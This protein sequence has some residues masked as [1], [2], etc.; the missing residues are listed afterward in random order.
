MISSKAEQVLH[1]QHK[2]RT[3]C[4]VQHPANA[5]RRRR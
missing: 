3:H 1:A 2:K 5:I 4:V